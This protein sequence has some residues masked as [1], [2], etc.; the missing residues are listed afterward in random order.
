MFTYLF[1]GAIAGS[2]SEYLQY[3]LP[4]VL[5]MSVLL[6]TVY[7]GVAIS[8]DMARGVSDRFRTM[9]IWGP[10]PLVGALVGDSPAISWREP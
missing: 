5:V 8:T 4:G 9:P 7:S 1:G 10:S 6:T 3:I 2:T